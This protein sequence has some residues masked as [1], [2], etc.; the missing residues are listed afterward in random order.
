MTI[1]ARFIGINKH[2]DPRIP[3]LS[4]AVRDAV[5]LWALWRDT[6]SGIDAELITDEQATV[7]TIRAALF[8]TLLNASEEDR[9]VLAFSGHGTRNHRLVAHDTA[10][11]Q[12]EA[13]TIPMAELARCFKQSRAKS[14]F[15]ILDCCFSGAAPARV[16]EDSPA[17]RELPFEV[18][19]ISGKGRVLI[20][21]SG[22]D[23]PAY[24]H[25]T[26]LHGLLTYALI[27]VLSDFEEEAS[28]ATLM[29]LVLDQVRAAA[30]TMGCTQTPVAFNL[31]EGGFKV[32]AL[33]RG[34]HFFKAFPD[35]KGVR[36]GKEISELAV[37]GVPEVV[38]N[39][40]A[41]L[42]PAGL[43]GLQLEAVNEYRVLDG[44][45]L[46]VVAPTSAGKTFIGEMAAVRAMVEGRKTALL[47]PYRALVNEKYDDFAELYGDR[48]NMRVIR[49]TGDYLDQTS[50]FL[51]GKFEIAILTFEM[52]LLL[53]IGKPATLS[54]LG[55]IILDEAQ[56]IT[57]QQR[58]IVVELILTRLRALREVGICPQLIALSATIGS[59]NHFDEWLDLKSLVTGVRP[60]PLE[61]GVLD[62]SGI[63][64]YLDP[65]GNRQS[66]QL[67]PAHR[68]LQRGRRPSSQDVL[69]PLV[70]QL[71]SEDSG[72]EK[73]LIFRNRRGAAEGCAAYLSKELGL[74]SATEVLEELPVHDLSTISEKLRQTL[75]GGVAFHNSNLTRDE[76]TLIE[77]SFRSEAGAVRVLVAT[78]TVA[79]GI[80]TPASTVVLVE[81]DFPWEDHLYS[82][83]EVRNMAGRAGRLG[84]QEA[85]RAIL[86]A[87]TPYERQR[88]FENYVL[89][90]P[91]AISSSFKHEEL[92]TWVLKLLAQIKQI[93]EDGLVGMV[94]NTYGGYLASLRDPEWQDRVESRLAHLIPRMLTAELLERTNGKIQL[95]LLGLACAQSSLSFESTLSLIEMLRTSPIRP[96]TP[97]HLMTLIQALP[98]LDG[99]YTPL[100]KKGQREAAWPHQLARVLGDNLLRVL[101]RGC[102]DFWSY[103]ARAKRACILFDWI[104]GRPIGTIEEYYTTNPYHAVGPGDVRSIA[105][106]TRFH[107]RTASGIVDVLLPSSA[108]DSKAMDTLLRQLEVGI[109]AKI[110]DLLSL[111]FRFERGE[112]LALATAE[113]ETPDEFW[114]LAPDKLQEVLGVT[115][116]K[117]VE[118]WRKR[119]G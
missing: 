58:G 106:T 77:R 49:C 60:V 98:E 114:A 74:S 116:A 30:L 4:G 92:D 108:P 1:N 35:K 65:A 15:C 71:F 23:E 118:R 86:L 20:T 2:L 112:Y 79:A 72:R 55:L 19:S 87:N 83:A 38:V 10:F 39:T 21:A 25:P 41:Q 14:I 75:G 57:D 67:I 91:E 84:Y 119:F 104:E 28:L 17:S 27:K 90:E 54:R 81:H 62:R 113:V 107:L 97:M 85:G 40:W 103:Y 36:V 59:L 42:F 94:A 101:Q 78:T 88:L 100:F 69:V 93:E 44:A 48:L 8:N 45:S 50:S 46:L 115:R 73:L 32:P 12:L 31:I 109:P 96:L 63:Y 82:V 53:A 89:G 51:M 61:M 68:I 11:E 37:F 105:D 70:Q 43:N 7:E 16:L 102:Q 99:L 66:K 56:F 24:E 13:S 9:V 117:E 5:A 29:D 80:N 52:F 6:V 110:L 95:T 47:L 22:L 33:K 3:D 76:R 34:V 64:E 26:H 111:P 18:E